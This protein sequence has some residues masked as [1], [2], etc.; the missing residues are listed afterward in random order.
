MGTSEIPSDFFENLCFKKSTTRNFRNRFQKRFRNVVHR[1]GKTIERH[2][3]FS[4]V[5]EK[6]KKKDNRSGT[7]QNRSEEHTSE[8]QSRENLVCRLLLEK[9]K[10][11]TTAP[12]IRE[13]RTCSPS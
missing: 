8:L 9:K 5:C 12:T 2:F 10:S 13:W 4:M 6:L 11:T 3:S 7:E 1:K